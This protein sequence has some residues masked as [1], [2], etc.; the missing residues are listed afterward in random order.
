MAALI[1]LSRMLRDN[2]MRETVSSGCS[3][4]FINRIYMAEQVISG[5]W[6]PIIDDEHSS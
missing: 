5:S 4:L 3:N 1:H 6:K 2:Q